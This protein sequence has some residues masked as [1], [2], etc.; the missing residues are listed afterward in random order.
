MGVHDTL[1]LCNTNVG[2]KLTSLAGLGI[3][4]LQHS[5]LTVLIIASNT[6]PICVIIFH[7]HSTQP[8]VRL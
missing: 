6:F 3:L 5:E 7:G 1:H 4:L 8:H 2:S